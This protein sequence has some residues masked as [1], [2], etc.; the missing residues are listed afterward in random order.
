MYRY[1][2]FYSP[3]QRPCSQNFYRP[4]YFQ[5][6]NRNYPPVDTNIFMSSAQK[7]LALMN[8]AQTLLNH[9]GNSN[10]FAYKLMNAAQQSKMEE[11][12]KLIRSTGVKVQPTVHIN[13]DGLQ[14]VFDEK[15]GV[16]DCCHVTVIVRWR[17]N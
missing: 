11:V 13:P 12:N 8:D 4:Q 17:E 15:L 2:P 1:H 16:I 3:S 7:T 6:Y 10:D 14:I 5:P 9:I